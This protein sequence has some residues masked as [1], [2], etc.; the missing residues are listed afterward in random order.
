MEYF[1]CQKEN[2][3]SDEEKI[4]KNLLYLSKK[5]IDFLKLM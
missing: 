5:L 1:I 4:N 3:I 2:T